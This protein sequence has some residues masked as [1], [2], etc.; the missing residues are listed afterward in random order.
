MLLLKKIARA[1]HSGNWYLV[2]LIGGKVATALDT[3][4]SAHIVSNLIYRATLMSWETQLRDLAAPCD[5]ISSF[6]RTR[7]MRERVSS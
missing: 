3:F 2:I 6:L 1:R 4:A 5:S 7:V